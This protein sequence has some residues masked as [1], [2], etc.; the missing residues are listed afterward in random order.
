M[1]GWVMRCSCAHVRPA[2]GGAAMNHRDYSSADTHPRQGVRRRTTCGAG[3]PEPPSPAVQSPYAHALAIAG[4]DLAGLPSFPVPPP[5]PRRLTPLPRQHSSPTSNGQLP[6][7]VGFSSPPPCMRGGDRGDGH[8]RSVCPSCRR[9]GR[10]AQPL[11]HP[12][13]K[14]FCV[15]SAVA[16]YA[17]WRPAPDPRPLRGLADRIAKLRASYRPALVVRI[18]SCAT[19]PDR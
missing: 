15:R 9:G 5:P 1:C 4:V 13:R 16:L 11:S 8:Q 18:A 10:A 2:D 14:R 7:Y 6:R 3:L 19:E 12:A 17:C